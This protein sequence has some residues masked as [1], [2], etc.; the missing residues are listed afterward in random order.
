V[1]DELNNY[2]DA[3]KR[4]FDIVAALGM[5]LLADEELMGRVPKMANNEIEETWQDI[6]Y[7]TDS[8]GVKHYGRIPK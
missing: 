8:N 5:A 1:L 2:T 6:G 7:Y 4:K 3:N